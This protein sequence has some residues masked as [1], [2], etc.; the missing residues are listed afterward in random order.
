ME[1]NLII[2]IDGPAGSGKSIVAEQLA[3]KLGIAYLDTGAMYRA[4]TWAVLERKVPLTDV[5][6]LT[7][8]VRKSHL[9]YIRRGRQNTIF[10]DGQDVADAIRSPQVTNQAHILAAIP[11]VR[12]LLVRRQQAIARQ[13]GSLVT[14]GRDQGTVV[15]PQAG[16]KF[17]LDATAQCRAERRQKQLRQQ[18]VQMSLEKVLFDQTQRDQRDSSRQVGP[19]KTAGD[20]IVVDTTDMSV[21]QVVEKLYRYIKEHRRTKI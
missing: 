2:T 7:E 11:A 9:E 1:E 10:L 6:A 18:G 3:Q 14:E 12:E 4:V 19:L 5:E 16:F 13:V 21:E 8:V 17:Y 15:F 20:A